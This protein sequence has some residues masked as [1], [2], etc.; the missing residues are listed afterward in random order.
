[1]FRVAC[2]NSFF[3][4]CFKRIVHNIYMPLYIY[5]R[6]DFKINNFVLCGKI[7]LTKN[8]ISINYA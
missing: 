5:S 4:L 7:H 2:T 3:K 6:K 8:N 1:M